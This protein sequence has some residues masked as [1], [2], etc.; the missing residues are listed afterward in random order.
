MSSENLN[1]HVGQLQDAATRLTEACETQDA[2]TIATALADIIIAADDNILLW[3]KH[4]DN[5]GTL[6]APASITLNGNAVQLEVDKT[7]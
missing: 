1:Y 7:K 4:T 3:D 5:T 2:A 6:H